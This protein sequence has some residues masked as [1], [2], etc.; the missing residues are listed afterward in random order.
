MFDA[1]INDFK[2]SI[3]NTVTEYLL[4]AAAVVPFL[5]AAGF[6]TAAVV[7]W[8][9]AAF[10]T[11]AAYL[12]VSV[13]FAVIGVVVLLIARSYEGPVKTSDENKPATDEDVVNA[14]IFTGSAATV[15]GLL[16]AHPT[17]LFAALRIM[18]R[19]L[20]ALIAGTIMG[21]LLF[22][23]SRHNRQTVVRVEPTGVRTTRTL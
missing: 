7:H 5:A 6:A 2:R 14:S 17:I 10:G 22:S 1:W 9:S 18:L 11:T 15:A 8:L 12:I 16:Y 19:N 21:G 20:P 4:L 3:S 13:G 23:D